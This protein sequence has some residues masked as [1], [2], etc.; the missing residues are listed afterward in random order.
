MEPHPLLTVPGAARDE[1]GGG[2]SLAASMWCLYLSPSL[3]LVPQC[4]FSPFLF[5]WEGFPKIDYR[6][7]VGT[8]I[9]TSL[10]EDLV[11]GG[12]SP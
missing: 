10:L 8:L 3:S 2:F 11:L 5:G 4:P 1:D 7:T 9:L 6:K 12:V